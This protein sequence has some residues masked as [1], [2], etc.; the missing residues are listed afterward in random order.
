MTDE[1]LLARYMDA[2][3]Q[4][5]DTTMNA[6]RGRALVAALMAGMLSFV[7]GYA[8][9]ASMRTGIVLLVGVPI[10]WWS[11][12]RAMRRIDR[13]HDEL[14]ADSNAVARE[15]V[16]VLG[17]G[18]LPVSVLIEPHPLSASAL[19]YLREHGLSRTDLHLDEDVHAC[20]DQAIAERRLA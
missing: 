10:A 20:L 2:G 14:A 3:Q 18:S 19:W 17:A 4:A 13:D 5:I 16:H 6:R 11:Y 12:V 8:L 7:L 15:G 9:W 1:M